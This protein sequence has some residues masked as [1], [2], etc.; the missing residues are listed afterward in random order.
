VDFVAL[1]VG[2]SNHNLTV[3]WA[4]TNSTSGTNADAAACIGRATL[5]VTQVKNFNQNA[6]AAW[7]CLRYRTPLKHDHS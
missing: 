6:R 4:M 2:Q 7:G 5:T 1:N 3:S